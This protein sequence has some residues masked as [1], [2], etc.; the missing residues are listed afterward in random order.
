MQYFVL[1]FK[2]HYLNKIWLNFDTN[3][4]FEMKALFSEILKGKWNSL[5]TV[6]VV[7][8][9]LSILNA[10]MFHKLLS[11]EWKSQNLV[12]HKRSKYKK[13]VQI[14]GKNQTMH[15]RIFQ[16]RHFHHIQRANVRSTYARLIGC[17]QFNLATHIWKF[18]LF[19]MCAW[20]GRKQ[21][22]TMK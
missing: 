21:L 7:V 11:M 16:M 19:I 1:N 8:L 4:T 6:V 12:K 2:L 15:K 13:R 20:W 18:H 14:K 22:Q 10:K 17:L 5:G 9:A 3:T